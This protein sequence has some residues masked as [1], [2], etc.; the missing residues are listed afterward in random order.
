MIR[1]MSLPSVTSKI[2]VLAN[3][4]GITLSSSLCRDFFF[5]RS[6]SS[7][8]QISIFPMSRTNESVNLHSSFKAAAS[9]VSS[10]VSPCESSFNLG[11]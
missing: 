3:L 5:E 2:S 6:R 10:T 9:A 8:K 4:S 11:R 1:L 7:A